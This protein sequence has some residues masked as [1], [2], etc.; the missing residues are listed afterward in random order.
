MGVISTARQ[1]D[2]Y[3]KAK[4]KK[5]AEQIYQMIFTF[6]VIKGFLIR[7]SLTTS[8]LWGEKDHISHSG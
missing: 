3:T 1:L 5:I 8:S 4:I 2:A 6:C 7:S